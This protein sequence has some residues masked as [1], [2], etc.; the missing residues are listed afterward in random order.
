MQEEFFNKAARIMGKY[1]LVRQINQ[2][3]KVYYLEFQTKS[4]FVDGENRKYVLKGCNKDKESVF[5]AMIE[6][7]KTFGIDMS[8]LNK[9]HYKELEEYI[10]HIKKFEIDGKFSSYRNA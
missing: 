9:A 7:H 10:F 6:I 1:K 2:P 5:N 3:G 8:F 4:I